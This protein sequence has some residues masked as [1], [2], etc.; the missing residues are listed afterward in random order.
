MASD[1]ATMMIRMVR[2][3]TLLKRSGI[4]CRIESYHLLT[5]GHYRSLCDGIKHLI[6][7]DQPPSMG[8]HSYQTVMGG[9]WPNKAS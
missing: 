4:D 2:E 3:V 8:A 6:P 7:S 1:L 5:F 9:I